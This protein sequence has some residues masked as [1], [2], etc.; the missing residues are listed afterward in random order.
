[1]SEPI[2]HKIKL[3]LSLSTVAKDFGYNL[4][5]DSYEDVF[6]D[7]YSAKD[8]KNMN[9]NLG[10][11]DGVDKIFPQAVSLSLES[12]ERDA[13]AAAIRDVRIEAFKQALEKIDLTGGYAEYQEEGGQMISAKAGI[14]SV[15]IN[16]KED[17]IEVEILNPEHLINTIISGRGY[18]A[19]DLP[20]FEKASTEEITQKFHHL[21]DYFQ[22]FGERLPSGDLSSQYSPSIN[23]DYFNEI[24]KEQIENLSLDEIVDSI[25]SIVEDEDEDILDTVQE[26]KKYVNYSLEEIKK[27]V[28][29]KKTSQVDAQSKE[30]KTWQDKLK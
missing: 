17:E 1:M 12:A 5:V 9:L 18:F 26:A 14:L 22:V 27:S 25:L 23:D 20:A 13:Y 11:L 28:L 16:E 21:K 2:N 4:E 10:K 8:I 15:E 30:L 24:L 19:S 3:K 29:E 6:H 7:G